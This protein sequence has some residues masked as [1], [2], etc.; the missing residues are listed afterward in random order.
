[1]IKVEMNVALAN[2]SAH[3]GRDE[4]FSNVLFLFEWKFGDW[5]T[6]GVDTLYWHATPE[7][8]A[9]TLELIGC[10]VQEELFEILHISATETD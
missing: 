10:D 8:Y 4:L 7:Q 2:Q 6:N 1:M 9:D 3:P 5:K